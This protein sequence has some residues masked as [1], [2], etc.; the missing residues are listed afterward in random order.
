MSHNIDRKWII[1]GQKVEIYQTE[2]KFEGPVSIIHGIIDELEPYKYAEKYKDI[3]KN[4]EW[5]LL[6]N[7]DHSFSQ[8]IDGVT[9]IAFD[10]LVKRE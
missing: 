2:E 5:H 4:R 9:S 1:A 6:E 10:F 3:Y 8:D 7:I